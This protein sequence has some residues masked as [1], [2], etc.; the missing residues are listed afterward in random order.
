MRIK[1]IFSVTILALFVFYFLE[2]KVE[3][4]SKKTIERKVFPMDLSYETMEAKNSLNQIRQS[5]GML[6]LE[7]NEEL[8]KAS[9][10][11]AKYMLANREYSHYEIEGK[12]NFTGIKPID[13]ALSTG[14]NAH[15]VSENLS[16]KNYSAQSSLDGLFSAIYHRFG[17][18]NPKIDEIGIAIDQDESNPKNSAFVYLMGNSR[19]NALCSG[20]SFNRNGRYVYGVCRDKKHRIFEKVY[21]RSINENMKYSPKIIV[22]P[23]DGQEDIFPAFYTETPDPLPNHEVSGFPM[24]IEFNEYYFKDVK[25]VSFKLFK[26]EEEVTDILHMDKSSDPNA[27]FTSHQYALFPL[28][29]LEYT[30]SYRVEVEY[31]SQK[32]EHS[33]SWSFKTRVPEGKLHT[34]NKKEQYITIDA[35]SSHI[36]YFKPLNEYNIIKSLNFPTFVDAQFIDNNTFRVNLMEGF[37][38]SFDIKTKNRVVHIEVK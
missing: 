7:S 20:K 25:L 10:A 15:G 22:Y 36:L 21:K 38:D 37:R 24:S 2:H 8:K 18:L 4:S 30:T 27:R 33:I 26:D 11:H 13:R 6:K 5:M 19:L 17:F 23:Y 28:K 12:S 14:Y 31:I 3:A 29:R 32:K 16:S 35:T 34:I 1:F 9:K